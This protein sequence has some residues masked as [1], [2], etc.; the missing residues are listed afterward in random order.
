MLDSYHFIRLFVTFACAVASATAIA[1]SGFK[2]GSLSL[3]EAQGTMFLGISHA[4]ATYMECV[5]RSPEVATEISRDYE[6]WRNNEHVLIARS[7]KLLSELGQKDTVFANYDRRIS[8]LVSATLNTSFTANEYHDAK[9]AM[10]DFC[11]KYFSGIAAGGHRAR[12]TEV[13]DVL[14]NAG[15]DDFKTDIYPDK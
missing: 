5:A 11:R 8:T 10:S 12:N 2:A 13:Y 14:E 9:A 3:E 7:V 6:T 1:G 4:K 15:N